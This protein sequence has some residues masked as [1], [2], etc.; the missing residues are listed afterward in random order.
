MIPTKLEQLQAEER[1]LW[2]SLDAAQ[3][4]YERARSLWSIANGELQEAK[5]SAL[6]E[7]R[8]QD[9]LAAI[10]RRGQEAQA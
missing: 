3:A 6:V 4:A 8:L 5:L 1:R 9:R 10:K 7:A 2:V